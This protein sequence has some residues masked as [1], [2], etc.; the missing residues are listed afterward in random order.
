MGSRDISKEMVDR[1]GTWLV[2][3][4]TQ[5]SGT[6][7]V[8]ATG[9]EDAVALLYRTEQMP[10]PSRAL[11]TMSPPPYF[12]RCKFVSLYLVSGIWYLV[13]YILCLVLSGTSLSGH[14]VE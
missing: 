4:G 12:V 8:I 1:G 3:G 2:G 10:P 6:M 11:Y 5:V 9:A 7:A 14:R 13:S